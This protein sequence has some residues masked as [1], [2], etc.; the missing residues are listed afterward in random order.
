MKNEIW[1]DIEGSKGYCQVSSYGR[2]RELDNGNWSLLDP[3]LDGK[4][5]SKPLVK[6][7][8]WYK[9]V[10]Y[11]VCREFICKEVTV[12]LTRSTIK[13]DGVKVYIL[14]HKDGSYLN[15]HV[16][17]LFWKCIGDSG[18]KEVGEYLWDETRS[19]KTD[20]KK[21][22]LLCIETGIGYT[23][24]KEASEAT[25]IDAELIQ[26]ACKHPRKSKGLAGGCHWK[27]LYKTKQRGIIK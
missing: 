7:N 19:Y 6:L 2:V 12:S 22:M 14:M 10:E 4:Y 21:N 13:D 26:Y 18:S 17:N 27:I 23:S 15:N 20:Y 8:G 24:F 1:R 5:G 11:L 25:G 3:E 9:M 16:D